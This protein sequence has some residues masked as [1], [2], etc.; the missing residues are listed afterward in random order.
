MSARKTERG[1]V[2]KEDLG[3]FLGLDQDR[4]DLIIRQDPTFPRAIKL[5][6]RTIRYDPDLLDIWRGQQMDLSEVCHSLADLL[7]DYGMNITEPMQATSGV[8]L[9]FEKGDLLYVGQSTNV[10]SRV[11][12]HRDKPYDKVLFLPCSIEVLDVV[13]SAL[14]AALRPRLN[15]PPPIRS[16]RLVDL[17]GMVRELTKGEPEQEE[18][19][20]PS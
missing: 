15:G 5:S 10:Y 13:E 6:S 14:I 17:P 11:P 7:N 12:Q 20:S 2:R 3:K 18:D 8:Y 1:L 4:V 19:P 9:L 16:M